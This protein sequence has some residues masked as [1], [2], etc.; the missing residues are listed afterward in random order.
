MTTA[1]AYRTEA[2]PPAVFPDIDEE[3]F[4]RDLQALR[5]E[6][7][8]SIGP[9]DRAHFR[10]I[11]RWGRVCSLLGYATSWVMPN[12][13]SALLIA[14]GNTAR[15]TMMAHH[16]T[17]RGYD[18]V[19]GMPEH[20][21]GKRFATGWRRFID[22]PDWIHPE[23]WRHE[24]NTLHHG[25][26]GETADPDL[27]EENTQWLRRSSM[28][29]WAKYAIVAFFACTWKV[30]YYAPNTFFEWRRAE[31]RRAGGA[32]EFGTPPLVT[33]FNPLTPQGRDFWST[34]LLPYAALR[35]VLLPALFAP[36][37]AWAVFSVFA[38]SVLAELLTNIQSFMLIAPNHAGDDLYRFQGRSDSHATFAVRQVVGSA[39]YATGS[40]GIDF[41]Q[42]FLNYQIEHHLWP[43]LPMRKYQQAQP[44]VKALCEKHG[45]PYVQESIWR[46]VG[47]LVD[48][49]VGRTS[50]RSLP[51]LGGR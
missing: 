48:I 44:R 31:R 47:K 3:A 21:T 36:L 30:T 37:G 9:E 49:M 19:P 4:A 24:H 18:R 2:P 33:A 41:L 5:V 40:D 32:E 51:T 16:V 27:V 10:K 38:N 34:C 25:R 15:W 42:G 1:V 11:Q 23:A 50:M 29:L 45:V 8:S 7:E 20:S 12:P 39:N 6:L 43:T 28:P 13:L 22:W 46:R 26:T 17:H 14:Q 35:F